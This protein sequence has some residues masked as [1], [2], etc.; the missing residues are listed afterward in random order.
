MVAVCYNHHRV[1]LNIN[2]PTPLYAQ[3]IPPPVRSTISKN[4]KLFHNIGQTELENACVQTGAKGKDIR[5]Y[6]TVQMREASQA[7]AVFNSKAK[8]ILN[9]YDQD[10]LRRRSLPKATT[11]L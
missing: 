4:A 11:A 9:F 1:G 5:I 2:T 7:S 3:L 10:E 8:D 6:L